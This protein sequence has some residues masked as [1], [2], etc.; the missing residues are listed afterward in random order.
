VTCSPIAGERLMR[1]PL[2]LIEILSPSNT[3]QTRANVWT[4]TTLPSVA[5]I[6]VIHSMVV[7]AELLR[8]A[9]DGSWPEQPDLIEEGG[10][11]RLDSIGLE[12][13]LATVYRT[14][15]AG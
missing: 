6:L 9:A 5:E 12:L 4:Y 3:D 10:I 13:P 7:N 15:L 14:A 2:L 11:L 1:D 8:R